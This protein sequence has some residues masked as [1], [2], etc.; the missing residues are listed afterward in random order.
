MGSRRRPCRVRQSERRPARRPPVLPHL[1]ARGRRRQS[2]RHRPLAVRFLEWIDRARCSLLIPVHSSTHLTELGRYLERTGI[3]DAILHPRAIRAGT[4]FRNPEKH[5][6]GLGSVE[7]SAPPLRPARSV[8]G[9]RCVSREPLRVAPNGARRERREGGFR[10]PRVR[11]DDYT[12][13]SARQD[14]RVLTRFWREAV[15][16]G[17]LRIHGRA[18]RRWGS[19]SSR[20]SR[21][22]V[23][24]GPRSATRPPEDGF[25]TELR[26]HTCLLARTG[27]RAQRSPRS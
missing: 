24:G 12:D 1:R 18:R 14:S 25:A 3:G 11:R 4:R 13:P 21:H 9:L 15:G 10:R 8:M 19:A 27:T 16:G 5:S 20:S 7:R 2:T 22:T 17:R 6:S 26:Q 23:D